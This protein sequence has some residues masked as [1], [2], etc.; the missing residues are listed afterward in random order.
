MYS[1]TAVIEELPE[2]RMLK[3]EI[4][5]D[6]LFAYESSFRRVE[7]FDVTENGTMSFNIEMAAEFIRSRRNTR[8]R[9]WQ[10]LIQGMR[11]ERY[12][13]N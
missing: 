8:D 11:R 1:D 10:S 4:M 13:K 7:Y 12:L 9:Y 3:T 5:A 6:R 2:N